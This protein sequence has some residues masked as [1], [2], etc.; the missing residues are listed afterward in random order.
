MS[1]K[2]CARTTDCV[3]I[4]T[5]DTTAL[6]AEYEYSRKTKTFKSKRTQ[7]E[8]GMQNVLTQLRWWKV[9]DCN[10]RTQEFL[11]DSICCLIN[12]TAQCHGIEAC[13]VQEPGINFTDHLSKVIVHSHTGFLHTYTGFLHKIPTGF[14]KTVLKPLYT[15]SLAAA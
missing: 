7:K 6:C 10:I 8:H 13:I 9:Q 1:E 15:T 4:D 11:Q 12:D 2:R 14:L 5:Y 3:T